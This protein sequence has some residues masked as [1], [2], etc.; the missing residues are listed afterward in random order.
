MF[1]QSREFPTVSLTFQVT[2]RSTG[3]SLLYFADINEVFCYIS[4]GTERGNWTLWDKIKLSL[5]INPWDTTKRLLYFYLISTSCLENQRYLSVGT[6]LGD[7]PLRNQGSISY[8]GKAYKPVLVS[9]QS[10]PQLKLDPFSREKRPKLKAKDS[11]VLNFE[12]KFVWNYIAS[13][14][15]TFVERCSQGP[16]HS[17]LSKHHSYFQNTIATRKWRKRQWKRKIFY[18]LQSIENFVLI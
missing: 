18:C 11:P 8:G 14:L 10:R 12:V 17:L 15:Y 5:S 7:K 16:L 3:L 1:R 2:P 13:S 9:K 4:V 6:R